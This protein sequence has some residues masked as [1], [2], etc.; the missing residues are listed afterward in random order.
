MLS[1]GMNPAH[2]RELREAGYEALTVFTGKYTN[3]NLACE[4]VTNGRALDAAWQEAAAAASY[5]PDTTRDPKFATPVT[6]Q[7][8]LA[9]QS[10]DGPMALGASECFL[11]PLGREAT[12]ILTMRQL[13]ATFCVSERGLGIS[14]V[15]DR[16]H[17]IP[18]LSTFTEV[19]RCPSFDKA[20]QY[21]A[22]HYPAVH[23]QM[24]LQR[25]QRGMRS[26]IVP[27]SVVA[28]EKAQK[29]AAPA[30]DLS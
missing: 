20:G 14:L 5:R 23:R 26:P 12:G 19:A 1:F 17:A 11:L 21:V 7:G 8:S 2:V 13:Y 3:E 25:E 9:I 29:P 15:E 6:S 18:G 4:L 22:K 30:P 28:A 24:T 27:P 16:P 10:P